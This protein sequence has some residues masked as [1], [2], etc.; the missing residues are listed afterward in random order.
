[1]S[2]GF[3][4]ICQRHIQLC[5]GRIASY[6]RQRHRNWAD[7]TNIAH[8]PPSCPDKPQLFTARTER[9][10]VR[11][12]GA[13]GREMKPVPGSW[14]EPQY[15]FQSYYRKYTPRTS[16]HFNTFSDTQNYSFC[17]ET[18]IVFVKN[19]P[20]LKGDRNWYVAGSVSNGNGPALNLV[21]NLG[22]NLG[23]AVTF[24]I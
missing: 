5:R 15:L 8:L 13:V 2:V 22:Q 4:H 20:G 14:T 23:K 16:K 3:R 21:W 11:T 7:V 24:G 17:S 10:Q 12:G 19:W 1:M 18:R 6:F 9:W